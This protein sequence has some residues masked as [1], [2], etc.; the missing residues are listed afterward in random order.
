MSTEF[1]NSDLTLSVFRP[2]LAFRVFHLDTTFYTLTPLTTRLMQIIIYLKTVPSICPYNN[3]KKHVRGRRNIQKHTCTHTHTHTAICQLLCKC[4]L[5]LFPLC[6]SVSEVIRVCVQQIQWWWGHEL[7]ITVC[8]LQDRKFIIAK[9]WFV[10]V[11]FPDDGSG[12]RY[13]NML[14]CSFTL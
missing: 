13:R 2:L 11:D 6:S 5:L 3:F 14:E 4:K 7:N 12:G 8:A 10:E 1:D 9:F